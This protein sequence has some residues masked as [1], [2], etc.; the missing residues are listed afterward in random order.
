MKHEALSKILL[1]PH[2]RVTLGTY[3][4]IHELCK[5]SGKSHVDEKTM[6][7]LFGGT[8]QRITEEIGKLI[9]LGLIEKEKVRDEKGVYIGSITT[10][11]YPN[12]E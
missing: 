9:N 1:S 6:L 11:K 8:R 5:P 4:L 3:A 10:D 2:P 12:E 7:A